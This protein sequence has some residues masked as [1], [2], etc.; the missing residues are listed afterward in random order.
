MCQVGCDA[1]ITAPMGPQRNRKHYL[2]CSSEA[3]KHTN[4]DRK[5]VHGRPMMPGV[6][7]AYHMHSCSVRHLLNRNATTVLPVLPLD[8]T[9]GIIRVAHRPCHV[10]LARV[11]TF[12]FIA[13]QSLPVHFWGWV[14]AL[15]WTAWDTER[16]GPGTDGDNV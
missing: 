8:T 2:L 12:P 3:A 9:R 15:A 13:Q 4:A 7:Q 6:R 5:T 14:S 1:S 16:R 10:L 11:V